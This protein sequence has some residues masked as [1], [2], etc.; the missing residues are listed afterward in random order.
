MQPHSAPVAAWF[1]KLFSAKAAEGGAIVRRSMRTV[2][3]DIG[4]DALEAEVRARGYHLV[5]CGGQYI[6]ICNP[7][8]LRVIC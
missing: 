3:R 2:D 7:G 1:D 8:F 4:R 5:E 6:V